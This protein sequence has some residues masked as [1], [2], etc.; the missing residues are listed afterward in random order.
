MSYQ[1]LF[2]RA[3]AANRQRLHF[4][5]HSHHLWPDASY[6]GHMEAWDDAARMADRK[7]DR[8]FG[9]V[10][11]EAQRHVASELSLPDPATIAFAPNTHDLLVRIVSALPMAKPHILASDGEF[12]SFRRQAMRWA[13]A[14]RIT[15]E[16]V[17]LAELAERAARGGFDLLFASQIQFNTG[18][19]LGDIDQFAALAGP[20][21]PWV[22]ID[23]YHGFM[24]QPTDLSGVA[25]RLFYLSGGYKY[26]M[27]G[28]GVCF[29]HAP[30]GYALRPEITGWFADFDSLE[31]QLGGVGY[32]PD[33][34]RFLGSTFDPAGLYRFN[35]VRRMLAAESLDTPVI[36]R[37][38]DGLMDAFAA[39]RPL[40][41]MEALPRAPRFI[42]FRGP[43]AQK[44]Q[45]RLSAKGIVIDR[46]AD[47][48]RIGFGLY[49]DFE[50]V[51]RLVKACR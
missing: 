8:I 36:S 37:Y 10:L 49:Q 29:L 9:E 4:A 45:E 48:L 32:A 22:V 6:D 26:A 35:G 44:W 50:D 15:L 5:A 43:D 1:Y 46:R 33:G 12:H 20:H 42:A 21:G 25:D 23:G 2:A 16:T 30:P 40:P 31:A 19:R 51:Q 14:G 11:P 39:A 24:A 34:L 41:G 13:E 47:V 18:A 38:C 28:E 7:W 27:A 3:L 17:P